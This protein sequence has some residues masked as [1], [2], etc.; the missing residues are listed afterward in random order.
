MPSTPCA[1]QSLL[2]TGLCTGWTAPFGWPVLPV[3]NFQSATSS[4]V[5]GAGSSSSE[6]VLESLPER[7]V[8]DENLSLACDLT[9]RS[10]RRFIGDDDRRIGVLEVVGVVLRLQ[11][12]VRL[13]GHRA[14]LLGAVPERDELDGVA[15]DQQN[16]V[17]GTHTD[18]EEK[19]AAAVDEARQ[20]GVRRL[21]G[22]ADERGAVATALLHVAVDEP[23]REVELAR[24]VGMR[25]HAATS[26]ISSTSI[27]ASVSNVSRPSSADASAGEPQYAWSIPIAT[28]SVWPARIAAGMST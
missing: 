9:D 17:L 14:D 13:R 20:L 28:K 18:L 21:A 6:S 12:R 3:V 1:Y 8:D 23:G 16:P 15:E 24:Q 27:S 19:V 26:R 5:V 22:R 4:F 25:D 7:L 2:S 11:E 10:L